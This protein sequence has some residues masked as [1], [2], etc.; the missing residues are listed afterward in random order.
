[1]FKVTCTGKNKNYGQA[2]KI[3]LLADGYIMYALKNGIVNP[4]VQYIGHIKNKSEGHLHREVP[5]PYRRI[6]LIRTIELQNKA[7]EKLSQKLNDLI[8]TNE[9]LKKVIKNG[10]K[11]QS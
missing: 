4:K 10:K 9:Q 2:G 11:E 7:I 1:M 8:K 5:L 3:R 6:D